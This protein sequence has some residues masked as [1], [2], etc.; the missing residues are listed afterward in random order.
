MERN[1]N[2]D[3]DLLNAIEDSLPDRCGV[4][5]DA[6]FNEIDQVHFRVVR[7]NVARKGDLPWQ[8]SIRLKGKSM[9][10]HWCGAVI[11][12]SHWILTAAHCLNGYQKSSYIVIAG[13]Y[14]MNVPEGTEQEA[15]I[16]EFYVHE[17]FRDKTK[18]NND[19]ALIKLKGK[20][21]ILN[22][23]VTAICLPDRLIDERNLN[24]TI[25]GFGSI[26]AGKSGKFQYFRKLFFLKLI[27]SHQIFCG[28][29]LL[30]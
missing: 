11:I 23:D 4:R 12:S 13:D 1:L 5:K 14:D 15:Y 19:I 28:P 2:T 22:G 3:R 29:A 30:G 10:S 26:E 16:E 20:G 18:M 6:L 21:L 25:S 9:T 17:K 8:A 24:C 27:H 7:G